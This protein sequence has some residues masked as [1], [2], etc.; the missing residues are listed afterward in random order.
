MLVYELE[1][2]PAADDDR[3]SPKVAWLRGPAARQPGERGAG[4][5]TKPSRSADGHISAQ[6][7]YKR[8]HISDPRWG[9]LVTSSPATAAGGNGDYHLSSPL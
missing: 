9:P 6:A 3:K 2:D 4:G 8:A 5:E 7:L 1:G